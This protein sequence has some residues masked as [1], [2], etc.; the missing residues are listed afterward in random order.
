M[1]W[2]AVSAI[3]EVV[4]VAGVVITLLYLSRQVRDNTRSIRRSTTHDALESIAGFNQ[5]VASDPE[6]VDVF[7]RGA[8]TPEEL[9]D[10][11]WQRFVSLAST[12]IRRFELLYLDH[13][14]GSLPDGIWT[15][16]SN[17]IRTWM[18]TP[19]AKKWLEAYG[20]H[21]HPAF[22]ELLSQLPLAAPSDDGRS[23][24]NGDR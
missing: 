5:F 8:Q 4:G 1:N 21:V 15:A 16:Q 6:L 20:G 14:D 2:S 22:G 18:T 17:N 7:W 19:G 11:E 3:A 23:S 13:L 12:L 24:E 10:A 9:S